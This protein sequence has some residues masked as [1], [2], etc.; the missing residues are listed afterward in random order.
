MGIRYVFRLGVVTYD[1]IKYQPAGKYNITIRATDKHGLY[2]QTFVKIMATGE[3]P[4]LFYKYD[5]T[6]TDNKIQN[7]NISIGLSRQEKVSNKLNGYFGKFITNIVAYT[8]IAL[9]TFSIQWSVCD[10][11]DKCTTTGLAESASKLFSA[12]GDILSEFTDIFKPEYTLS[13]IQKNIKPECDKTLT[14]PTASQD[15]Y[16]INIPYC[17]GFDHTFPNNLITDKEDGD[18]S[19][20]MLSFESPKGK[21]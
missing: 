7:F 21:S 6:L 20:L 8:E 11:P 2:A 10:L 9:K 15:P 17:G 5:M 12:S 13:T 19:A 1:V 18:I 14:P 3:L 4:Q 16:M